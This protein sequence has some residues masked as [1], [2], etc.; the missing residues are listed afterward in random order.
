MDKCEFV[1]SPNPVPCN[2]EGA[3]VSLLLQRQLAMAMQLDLKD[4]RQEDFCPH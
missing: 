4:V 3:G 2:L 1:L